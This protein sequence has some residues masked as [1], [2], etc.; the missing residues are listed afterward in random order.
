MN[1][2]FWRKSDGSE[3]DLVVKGTNT[4]KA[5]EIKWTKTSLTP[6]SRSFSNT[7]NVPVEVITKDTI[8][9]LLWEEKGDIEEFIG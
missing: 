7:Y 5:Y 9:D 6:S 3:V 2:Y 1:I 8:L 4:F